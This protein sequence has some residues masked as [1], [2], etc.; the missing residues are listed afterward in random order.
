MDISTAFKEVVDDFIS[1]AETEDQLSFFL[2][3]AVTAWNVSLHDENQRRDLIKIFIDRFER[4]TFTWEDHVISTEEK[5]LDICNK[6][7]MMYPDLRR[8][9]VS[10][11]MEGLED[12]FQYSVIS[13]P[14]E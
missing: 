2:T 14:T 13:R 3:L 7:I 10:L 12:G 5:I 1:S 4:P 11:D 6:K 8:Q 9:I